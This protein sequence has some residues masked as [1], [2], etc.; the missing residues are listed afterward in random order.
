VS[1]HDGM[2][3]WMFVPRLASGKVALLNSVAL[4]LT[5]L[6]TLPSTTNLHTA[7]PRCQRGLA[8]RIS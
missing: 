6:P 8:I 5:S 1:I 3:G 7:G 4:Q 2:S